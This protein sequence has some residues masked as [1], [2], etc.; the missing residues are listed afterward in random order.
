ML[1]FEITGDRNNL[2]DLQKIYFETQC[3][4]TQSIVAELRYDK[5]DPNVS[6]SLFLVNN[7][8]FFEFFFL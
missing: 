6:D 7:S 1:E 8:E 2:V 3:K 4:V 5:D